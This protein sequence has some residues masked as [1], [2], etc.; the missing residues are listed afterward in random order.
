MKK[1]SFILSLILFSAMF[2]PAQAAQTKCKDGTYSSSTG[3]GTCSSH[4]G[5]ASSS[6]AE[7]DKI[8]A[9]IKKN[10]GITINGTTSLINVAAAEANL[11][12][13]QANQKADA[14]RQAQAKIDDAKKLEAKLNPN[15]PKQYLMQ[16]D[17]FVLCREFGA[18]HSLQNCI[19]FVICEQ[20]LV[21]KGYTT[22]VGN[23]ART[24]LD[25]WISGGR[26]VQ[27]E[28]NPECALIKGTK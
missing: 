10:Y 1:V 22:L 17:N 2:T 12:R 14:A 11:K 13:Q 23:N 19:G 3:R 21:N 24:S 7:Y 6:S 28:D 27:I 4:G 9:R 16:T 18:P 8:V 15:N 26:L 20:L 25:Y 5:V